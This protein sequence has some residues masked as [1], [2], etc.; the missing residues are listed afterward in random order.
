MGQ[1]K[2]G[3]PAELV[4]FLTALSAIWLVIRRTRPEH[5][6]GPVEG[7][8]GEFSA[9]GRPP[10]GWGV[11]AR[12]SDKSVIIAFDN[13][14]GA[15]VEFT[16]PS[17]IARRIGT[18]LNGEADIAEGLVSENP[19]ERRTAW[20]RLDADDLDEGKNLARPKA[21]DWPEKKS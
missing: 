6:N 2:Y 3:I 14:Q 16:A 18:A 19:F 10:F 21:P 4:G 8:R 15:R 1:L 20:E 12:Q 5:R 9:R 13:R 11:A 7:A 17:H